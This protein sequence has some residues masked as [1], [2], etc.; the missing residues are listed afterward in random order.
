MIWRTKMQAHGSKARSNSRIQFASNES[1]LVLRNLDPRSPSKVGLRLWYHSRRW[2][3]GLTIFFGLL[4]LFCL[5][6]FSL[7]F[8]FFF[9]RVLSH[10]TFHFLVLLQVVA[11]FKVSFFFSFVSSFLF[12]FIYFFC[13]LK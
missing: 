11:T 8:S 13:F 6:S 10:S 5:L 4:S 7:F 1:K 2:V 12:L 9:F 3:L